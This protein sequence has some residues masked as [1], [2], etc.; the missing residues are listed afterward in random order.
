MA[1]KNESTLVNFKVDSIVKESAESVLAGMGLNMSSYIGM[2]LRQV[3]QDARIPFTP[4][5]NAEFWIGEAAVSKAAK[6]ADSGIIA[7]YMGVRGDEEAKGARQVNAK[8]IDASDDLKPH[9]AAIYKA[10]GDKF[11]PGGELRALREAYS[12][13]DL[14]EGEDLSFIKEGFI[15]PLVKTGERLLASDEAISLF[16][17]LDSVE[18]LFE[19][20]DDALGSVIIAYRE[21]KDQLSMRFANRT[22]TDAWLSITTYYRDFLRRVDSELDRREA[23]ESRGLGIGD[24][25]E[26]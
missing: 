10:V 18:E 20:L 26:L 23:E 19:Y 22:S 6:V 21:Y 5:V 2:C 13:L 7:E 16:G 8:R 17:E 1:E 4:S 11:L 14:E 25:L 9:I 12:S 24:W 3:A 15:D